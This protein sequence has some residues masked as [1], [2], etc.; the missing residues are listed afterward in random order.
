MDK[1]KCFYWRCGWHGNDDELLSAPDPFNPGETMYACPKCRETDIVSGCD[2]PG[3]T[4][5][6]TCGWPSP[7]GYRRTCVD[8]WRK[9]NGG[10]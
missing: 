2:E 4:K 9:A 7:S 8:H 10:G 1:W 5:E 3:C 6:G